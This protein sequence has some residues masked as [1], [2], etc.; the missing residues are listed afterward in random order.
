MSTFRD[1]GEHTIPV[2]LGEIPVTAFKP[3]TAP[4]EKEPSRLGLSLTAAATD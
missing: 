2:T 4:Q 3:A 1:G